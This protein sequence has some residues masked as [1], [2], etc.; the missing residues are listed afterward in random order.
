M[1]QPATETLTAFRNVV[2]RD[3]F[4][5]QGLNLAGAGLLMQVRLDKDTPGDP[6]IELEPVADI[7]TDEGLS[8]S[9]D[10]SGVQPVSTIEMFIKYNTLQ[11][12]CAAVLG[13]AQAG[14]TLEL[15]YDLITTGVNYN[16]VMLARGPFNIE[17]SVSKLP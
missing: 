5:F 12:V 1:L 8:L 3:S 6:L 14:E 11:A 17:G 2:F 9:V 13:D 10:T 16:M 7:D 15:Q 4:E